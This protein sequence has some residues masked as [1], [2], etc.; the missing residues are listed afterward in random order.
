MGTEPSTTLNNLVHIARGR[1]R[2]IIR[3]SL[4]K[5]R[6]QVTGLQLRTFFEDFWDWFRY[7]NTVKCYFSLLVS[8]IT[9]HGE[10]KCV[11]CNYLTLSE[12]FNSQLVFSFFDLKFKENRTCTLQKEPPNNCISFHV[13]CV[14]LENHFITIQPHQ[15]KS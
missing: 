15:L 12:Y 9:E 6:L 13:K 11:V 2:L 14:W 7:F 3:I 1:I 5:F 8:M 4:Q 10:K